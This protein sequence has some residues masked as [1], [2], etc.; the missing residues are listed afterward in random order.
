MSDQ[1]WS[2]L[3]SYLRRLAAPGTGRAPD[4]E[5]LQRFAQQGDEAAFEALLAR[6]GPMVLRVGQRLLHDLHLA[7]DVFQATFLTLA[8]K[9]GSIRRGTSLGSWLHGVA[10]H[11]A[12]R[13]RRAATRRKAHERQAPQPS[14]AD[15]LA[16]VSLREAVAV[17]DEELARLPE[18]LRA[19]L[20][21]C[22]LE[23]QTRDE[24]ARHL[25]WSRAT[26]N[27]RLQQGRERLQARL[28][29]RGITLSA[30]L[31]AGL[32]A[33]GSSPAAV[34]L[35]LARLTVQAALLVAQGKA[36]AGVVSAEA[37]AL[38]QEMMGMMLMSKVKMAA[39]LVLGV[40]LMT[41][42]TAGLAYF[43]R[44]ATP[45]EK[46]RED[47][48]MLVAEA[49]EKPQALPEQAAPMPLPKLRR[50]DDTDE[51]P[52][53]I[54]ASG[55][56]VDA[57]GKPVAGAVVL[58]RQGAYPNSVSFGLARLTSQLR[59]GKTLDLATA[60]TNGEGRF[61]F[62]DVAL[63]Q[64]EGPINRDAFPLDVIVRADGHG[65]AWNHFWQNDVQSPL[66]L[67]L[68]PQ[69]TLRGRLVASDGK[70][71]AGVR[72]RV[73]QFTPLDQPA[74][75]DRAAGPG[76][77]APSPDTRDPGFLDLEWASVP[78]SARTDSQGRFQIAGLPA[79]RRVTLAVEDERFV[80]QEI[81]AATTDTPQPPVVDGDPKG[82]G[83][84][85]LRKDPVYTG[86]FTA[87]LEPGW[88]L[89]VRV[90]CADTGEPAAGEVMSFVA[91]RFRGSA[92]AS[93][94]SDADG[95]LS[96]R[97]FH[98]G[99]GTV[100][101]NPAKHRDYWQA[102]ARV[103]IPGD[104]RETDLSIKLER[105]AVRGTAVTGWVVDRDT[106][107]GIAG[108]S[109]GYQPDAPR[110]EPTER[111]RQAFTST[112]A[113]GSF[114]ITVPS[115]KGTVA[116]RG[117]IP[118]GYFPGDA[119]SATSP[120]DLLKPASR[121][122][123]VAEGRPIAPVRFAL[124]RGTVYEGQV[125][126]P[127]GQPVKPT[128]IQ[129][130]DTPRYSLFGWS[131]DEVG[132]ITMSALDP[133]EGHI[134]AVF[135]EERRLAARVDLPPTQGKP[136]PLEITLQPMVSMTGRVTA[137]DG[138][139]PARAWVSLYALVDDQKRRSVHQ[140]PVGSLTAVD[141]E[142]KYTFDRLVPGVRYVVG[143]EIEGALPLAGVLADP[144]GKPLGGVRVS[145]KSGEE[146]RLRSNPLPVI[147]L[148]DE[149]GRFRFTTLSPGKVHLSA[150][151]PGNPRQFD[152]KTVEA[153]SLDVRAVLNINEP[154]AVTSISGTV[155]NAAG[156][157][158]IS[159]R[160]FVESEGKPL[161]TSG[162][163]DQQ[164]Q[165]T[166]PDLPRGKVRLIA[167]PPRRKTDPSFRRFTLEDIEV[168]TQEV[169]FVVDLT[170]P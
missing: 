128:R 23:G 13:A 29:R 24:A 80:P 78:L 45:A 71:A 139:P 131:A 169:R 48:P 120:A 65:L 89:R 99:R 79:N 66:L 12:L 88:L 22:F 92:Q 3:L 61:T 96:L 140:L 59:P 57:A 51:P 122:I 119:M 8:R 151:V 164:G 123:D 167:V 75:P 147:R 97:I 70:P 60:T 105:T 52:P 111:T 152:L 114:R 64:R 159:V 87:T 7:E 143:T 44:P 101:V 161:R 56:V 53:R 118:V 165:F 43:G 40:G 31:L 38:F 1:R 112:E 156:K 37:L 162:T 127:D 20:V 14:P 81:Y 129:C 85:A 32:G 49:G 104:R 54:S 137:G 69:A 108:V 168:G 117:R 132:R 145:A 33:A 28:S 107:T 142:G 18:R 98:P 150:V 10:Y 73:V 46:Q 148:T 82:Q 103:D 166:I 68:A 26:F 72:L 153:G 125:R 41:A 106:G 133:R 19:P 74:R 141:A 124:R 5:L 154:A 6:H 93:F 47:R 110:K 11:L 130:W 84:A 94:P 17:L 170:K 50:N 160:I 58:L 95:R 100:T 91:D 15:P 113:D 36:V 102:V 34:P 42:G 116:I 109:I 144:Q 135:N 157:P 4:Q 121:A 30:A 86:D 67:R 39:A 146:R 77:L 25:G 136:A 16:E 9:A 138:K 21:L 27:R 83:Q 163:T 149:R 62:Q 90:V 63:L 115:G 35:A 158:L 76:G 126:D 55:G 155:V 2:I 134:L